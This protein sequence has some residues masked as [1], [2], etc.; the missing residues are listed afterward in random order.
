MRCAA[1]AA[2]LVFRLLGACDLGER[3][4]YRIA[5]MPPV[6]TGLLEGELAWSQAN[7][8]HEDRLNMKPFVAWGNRRFNA[9]SSPA[10]PK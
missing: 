1:E 8:G 3:G 7:G 4:D 6:N 2:G 9:V 5:T 10:P